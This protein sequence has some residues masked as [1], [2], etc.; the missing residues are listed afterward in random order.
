MSYVLECVVTNVPQL[1]EAASS[2]LRNPEPNLLDPILGY[3]FRPDLRIE[4]SLSRPNVSFG[5]LD[6]LR[7]LEELPGYEEEYENEAR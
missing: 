6:E 7:A 2:V 5:S 1:N 4:R 3:M